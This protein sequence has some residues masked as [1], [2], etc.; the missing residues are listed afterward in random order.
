M[1][2]PAPSACATGGLYTSP[3]SG[4]SLDAKNPLNISWDTACMSG[5]QSVDIY[6][7]APGNDQP[8]IHTWSSVYFPAG[9]YQTQLQP[10]WWNAT[11]SVSLQLAIVQSGL[12]RAMAQLPAGPVWNA[13]TDTSSG[14]LAGDATAA[15]T[16]GGVTVVN[17][18]PST[19]HG[20]SKGK[21]AA[22]VIMPLLFIAALIGLAFLKISRDRGRENRKRFS[23][24]VDKRM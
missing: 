24:A 19:H 22:A 16:S 7:L 3:T 21:I 13:T 15:D 8:L 20:L 6:L 11:D 17:N 12:P 14:T 1:E 9:S 10:Q 18:A 2:A 4:Q 5:A 23:V